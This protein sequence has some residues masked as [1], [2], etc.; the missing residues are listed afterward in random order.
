MNQRFFSVY[1]IICIFVFSLICPAQNQSN[2]SISG[3]VLD[4]KNKMPI[5]DVYV[6]LLN[7]NYSSLKRTRT[8]GAGKYFFAGIS[9]GN[10]KVKVLPYGTNYLEE[11]GEVSIVNNRIGAVVTSEN[12]YLDL[13]LRPDP[14][15]ITVDVNGTVGAIF[16]QE[17]PSNAEKLYKT[18]LTNFGK[19]KEVELGFENLKKALDI[20]P[21]YYDA[22]NR[23]SMEYVRRGKYYESLPY[24]IKAVGIN[25]R[26]YSCH[27]FL[28]LAAFNLKQYKESAEAF[29]LATVLNPDSV[30]AHIQYGMLSRITGSFKES[31]KTLL[32]AV[33]LSKE[34]PVAEVFLQ[35][36]LLYEKLERYDESANQLEK[37][38][39][40]QTETINKPQI[41]N[42]IISL[43][44]KASDKKLK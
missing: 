29:R 13:Y 39:K 28:G 32:K 5:A 4:A 14:R 10:F 18:S 40:Y 20:F 24:V 34:L 23:I 38:L 11:I 21:D 25:K 6:E 37:Y 3:F 27:Y 8:D 16:V 35:L 33:S 1:T 9:S 17:I 41:Q 44:K 42:T 26:S 36:A 15:K 31:E 12:G 30:N 22:L 43:R 2:N 19:E 7:D